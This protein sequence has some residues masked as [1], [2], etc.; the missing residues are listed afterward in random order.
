MRRISGTECYNVVQRLRYN[1]ELNEE[2]QVAKGR[3]EVIY[4]DKMNQI[5]TTYQQNSKQNRRQPKK[6]HR[7]ET[8]G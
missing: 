5:G 1:L 4:K 8:K 2:Y 7:A 3:S 6:I